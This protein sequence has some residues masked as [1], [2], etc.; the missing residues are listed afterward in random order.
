MFYLVIFM[1]LYYLL[2]YSKNFIVDKQIIVLFVH[3][4]R[5]I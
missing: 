4:V 2:K 3:H 1:I 5:T